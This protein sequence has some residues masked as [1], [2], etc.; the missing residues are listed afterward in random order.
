MEL[1]KRN[2]IHA[3]L[4]QTKTA[5]KH[6]RQQ[7]RRKQQEPRKK[8]RK[9]AASRPRKRWV[10]N[11]QNCNVKMTRKKLIPCKKAWKRNFAR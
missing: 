7:P 10:R 8:Q 3:N 9:N 6:K 11:L 5:R 2:M 4:V 1:A